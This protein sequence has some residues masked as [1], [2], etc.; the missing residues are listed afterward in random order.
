MIRKRPEL[1]DRVAVINKGHIEQ[2]G[3]PFEIY[4]QPAT[5]YVATFLGAANLLDAVVRDSFVEIGQGPGSGSIGPG[6]IQSRRL[7]EDCLSTRG[8]FIE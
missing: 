7:R 3:T 1:G 6:A 2:I 8:R 4:S 5:E